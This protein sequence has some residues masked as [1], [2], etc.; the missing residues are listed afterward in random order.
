MKEQIWPK[1]IKVDKRIVKLLSGA[2]Y[3]NFPKALKELIVNSYDADAGKVDI[4]IDLKKELISIEDNGHGM[5]ELDFDFYLRIAFQSREKEGETVSGRKIIGQ[6]GVGFLSVFP[7][8]K[9]YYIESS[10]RGSSEVV[11]ANI[12]SVNYFSNA[13]ELIEVEKIQ[14]PGGK[15]IDRTIHNKQFTRIEMKGFTELTNQFFDPKYKVS[16]NHF[17]I[18]N[19]KPMDQLIWMMSEDLPVDY[20]DEEFKIKFENT[21]KTPF[22][23]KINNTIIKRNVHAKTILET[24]TGE[25]NKIGKIKFKYFIATKYSVINPPEARFFKIRNLNVGVG[26]RDTF[27]AGTESGTRASLTHLTGDINIIEGLNDLISLDRDKFNYDEDYEKLKEY[28]RNRLVN[29]ATQTYDI[30]TFSKEVKQVD[31]LKDLKSIDSKNTLQ[32]INKLQDRGFKV[33]RRELN[34]NE[35][36]VQVNKENK[37][38][39]ISKDDEQFQRK[40]DFG[41]INYNLELDS[42]EYENSEFPALIIRNKKIVINKNYPLF[43][44]KKYTDVFFRFH[45]ILTLNLEKH[46]IDRQSFS[47][48]NEDILNTFKDYIG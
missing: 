3:E 37:T 30:N 48:I 1:S 20:K 12:P 23:V 21:T 5:S 10:K 36:P 17:S 28:F 35:E 27:G 26:Q 6:F 2:T 11:Y 34:K 25:Y 22:I 13:N 9:N 39:V 41:K 45:L 40:L 47:K 18:K 44:G 29:L 14:I 38:I 16:T 24:H 31:R 43:K 46:I 15:K 32:K 19:W 8:C 7:F 42:W 33:I 4:S